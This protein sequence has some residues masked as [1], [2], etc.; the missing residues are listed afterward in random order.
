MKGAGKRGS[1]ERGEQKEE[2]AENKF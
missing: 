1:G 2:E